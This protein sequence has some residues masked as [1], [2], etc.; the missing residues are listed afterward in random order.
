MDKST[1]I[2]IFK[3]VFL[4]YQRNILT[5]TQNNLQGDTISRIDILSTAF[6]PPRFVIEKIGFL[7]TS[8]KKYGSW[9]S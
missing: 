7:I 4:E 2:Y 8:L 3:I 6:L 9:E 1:K 5:T